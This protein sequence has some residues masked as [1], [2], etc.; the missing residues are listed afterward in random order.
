MIRNDLKTILGGEFRFLAI[1]TREQLGLTQR[2]MGERLQMSESNYS[3]NEPSVNNSEDIGFENRPEPDMAENDRPET[4]NENEKSENE[5]SETGNNETGETEQR[6]LS[7]LPPQCQVFLA[8]P[9]WQT[10]WWNYYFTVLK[11]P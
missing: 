10:E 6:V 8:I 7:Y 2:E 5:K 11:A 1:R 4:G 3:Q 9:R